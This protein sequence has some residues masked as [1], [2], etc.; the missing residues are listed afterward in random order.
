MIRCILD[1]D[2][3]LQGRPLIGAPI[4]IKQHGA[5]DLYSQKDEKKP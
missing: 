1:E 5:L 2:P 3:E 4:Q